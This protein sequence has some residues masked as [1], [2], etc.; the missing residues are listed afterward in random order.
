[1][2]LIIWR[3][4]YRS[5]AWYKRLQAACRNQP[6]TMERTRSLWLLAAVLAGN[7]LVFLFCHSLPKQELS[8][9]TVEEL[10][11]QEVLFSRG[12][13]ESRCGFDSTWCDFM[14]RQQGWLGK[15]E[16]PVQLLKVKWCWSVF[17]GFY[18]H[19]PEPNRKQVSPPFKLPDKGRRNLCS[20]YLANVCVGEPKM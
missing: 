17:C 6:W 9:L 10:W 16:I 18:L 1:M 5:S 7:C 4:P 19:T 2:A 15:R 3:D 13:G 11:E 8:L 12:K 20:K 14:G